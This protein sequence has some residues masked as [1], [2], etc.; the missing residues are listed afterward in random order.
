MIIK[1]LEMPL[2]LKKLQALH[3]RLP[4]NHPKY[5]LVQEKL[6]KGLAGYKGEVSV[7]YQLS[8]LPKDK[9]LIFHDIRLQEKE[10]FFQIDFL[11]L[12]K[13]FLTTLEVKN[14]AGTLYFDPIFQQLIRTQN[15]K[16]EAFPDPLIQIQRHKSLMAHWLRTHSSPSIP[17]ESLI[18]ISSPYTLLKTN[19]KN[20]LISRTILHSEALP[21]KMQQLEAKY[22]KSCLEDRQ[23]KKLSRLILKKN[24]P[25]NV[26]I[27]KQYDIQKDELIT[28]VICPS[29][30]ALPMGRAYGTWSCLQCHF[31]AA[32]CHVS[33]LDDYR[34]LIGEIITNSEARYF[35]HISSLQL[36]GRLL[37]H[38]QPNGNTKGRKYILK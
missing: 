25:L 12:A 24:T 30:H 16:E 3:R 13:D 33:A 34:L 14:I 19:P 31:K 37:H 20:E 8:L 9:Y 15:E 27:L 6:A 32:D 11:L 36:A 29:C 26:D 38:A 10:H 7:E 4:Q 35:L 5:A 23:W 28:G 22:R 2:T 18:V 21:G 17:I 1:K